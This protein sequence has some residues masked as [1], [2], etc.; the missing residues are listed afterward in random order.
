MLDVRH[1]ITPAYAAALGLVAIQTGI[2]I[3]FKAA[4]TG[5]K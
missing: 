1:L 2:G 3:L 5:G 4:Q